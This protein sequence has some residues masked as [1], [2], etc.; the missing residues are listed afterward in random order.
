MCRKNEVR[1]ALSGALEEVLCAGRGGL[2]PGGIDAAIE[3]VSVVSEAAQKG[4]YEISDINSVAERV[5]RFPHGAADDDA[6]TT[7]VVF[8]SPSPST[9][10]D[11]TPQSHY[12]RSVGS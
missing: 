12:E 7:E 8:A 6:A 10:G 9:T 11:D 4:K 5:A 3:V 1:R 2:T